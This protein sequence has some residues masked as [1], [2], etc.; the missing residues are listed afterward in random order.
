[1]LQTFAA[2]A[3]V[4]RLS[5]R[6]DESVTLWPMFSSVGLT[7]DISTSGTFA[8]ISGDERQLYRVSDGARIWD[9]VPPPG[10][11]PGCT[12]TQLRL[13]PTG[14]WAAGTGYANTL[15]VFPTASATPWQVI[16]AL[17]S[18]CQDTAA[19]SRDEK[20]MATSTPAVY[21]T[22]ERREDWKPLWAKAPLPPPNDLTGGL[23]NWG[24]EVRFSP[25][26]TKLLVSHCDL[27]TCD[28]ALYAVADGVLVQKLP[29]LTAPHPSFSSEGQWVVAGATLQHLPSGATR[30]FDNSGNVTVAIFAPNGDIIAGASDQSVTRYCRDP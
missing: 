26:E 20:L 29:L 9:S 11:G 12:G 1:M 25:D 28:A 13:S 14:R 15:D 22:G 21:R 5:A 17:A 23:R 27:W 19:F 7:S 2:R 24:N 6:F 8:A 18:G 3:F 30:S 16:A 10:V 4:L